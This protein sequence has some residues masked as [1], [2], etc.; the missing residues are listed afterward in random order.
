MDKRCNV[1]KRYK[2]I[3]NFGKH[4]KAPDGHQ[5]TCS[6]CHRKLIL[7]R[8]FKNP[9]QSKLL[10]A[11]T[12]DILKICALQVYSNGKMSCVLCEEDDI[13]VLTIDHIQGGGNQHRK[14]ANL[15]CGEATYKWLQKNKYPNGFRVL[16]RN[17]NCRE[18]LKL[19]SNLD[20]RK[21]KK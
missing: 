15:K 4:P 7:I 6:N 20:Y 18:Y 12:Y 13:D 1:C 9:Y 10:R 8:H 14:I 19:N 11:L 2:D 5:Y 17:C 3:S 16:C 21:W